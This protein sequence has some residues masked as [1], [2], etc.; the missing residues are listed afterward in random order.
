[1]FFMVMVFYVNYGVVG[2]VVWIGVVG[3]DREVWGG[4]CYGYGKGKGRSVVECVGVSGSGSGVG[5]RRE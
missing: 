3:K 2:R 4:R 5:E 1:M